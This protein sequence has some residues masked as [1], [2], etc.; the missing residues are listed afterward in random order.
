MQVSK[1][2][3]HWKRMQATLDDI[4]KTTPGVRQCAPAANL[5]QFCQEVPAM[6]L[7]T[8]RD[9]VYE[10]KAIAPNRTGSP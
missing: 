7:I 8:L 3:F 1:C 4:T 6:Q 2:A 5:V 10:G 9:A